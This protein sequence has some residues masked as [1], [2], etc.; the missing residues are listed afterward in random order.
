MLATTT[1]SA[2]TQQDKLL[3]YLIPDECVR[4]CN[5]RHRI[6][7][8]LL[9]KITAQT[10]SLPRLAQWQT[11]PSSPVQ[12]WQD[13]LTCIKTEISQ[14]MH[15]HAYYNQHDCYGDEEGQGK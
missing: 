12:K 7:H 1:A 6:H 5:G 13:L 11:V 10:N 4:G 15:P 3:T 14:N 8:A 2:G 9:Q